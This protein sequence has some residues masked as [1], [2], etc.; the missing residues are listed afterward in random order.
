MVHTCPRC[1]LRFTSDPELRDHLQ[2]DHHTDVGSFDRYHYKPLSRPST[3]RYLVVANQTLLDSALLDRVKVMAAEGAHFHVVV[4]A[5]PQEGS[6]EE[7]D[8][9]GLALATYRARHFVDAL[10]G[11]GIDAEGEVGSPDPVKAV[12]RAL[13]HEPA[14]EIVVS[15]LRSG[16]SRWLAVDLP[17]L[18]EH[19]FHLPVTVVTAS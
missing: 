9:K 13:E 7:L 11:A 19:E 15:T 4:P 5:T 6:T 1:E 17:K 3:K 10:H 16:M 14:D 18:L 8:D 2:V 12:A